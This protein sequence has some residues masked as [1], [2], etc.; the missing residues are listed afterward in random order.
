MGKIIIFWAKTLKLWGKHPVTHN[1]MYC[2]VGA[3]THVKMIKPNQTC[4]VR[5]GFIALLGLRILYLLISTCQE[6]INHQC[7][8]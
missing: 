4:K 3:S 2:T 7:M 8:P 5:S 1:S 6:L